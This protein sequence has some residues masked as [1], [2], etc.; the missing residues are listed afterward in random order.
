MRRFLKRLQARL[1]LALAGDRAFI[2]RAF[3]EILGRDPDLDGLNHYRRVL[4]DGVGRT[5]VLLDIL[6]S[7]ESVGR[8]VKPRDALVLPDLRAERPDR[9]RET[10]DRANGETITVFDIAS[11]ADVDWL[12]RAI[13][14]HRYYEKPGVWNLGVD[15]DKR[16]V[17]EIIAAF[18]P[19]QALELGCAAG[20]VL[21]CL[22]DVGIAAEGVEI[23]TMAIAKASPR[24]RP[25]IHQG[26][27]LLLDLPHAYDMVFGLDV[28]E[29]LNPNRIDD[30]V[31]RLAR[32]TAADAMLF[33]NIPAFGDDPVFGTVFP[34][35]V[36]GWASD[37]AAGRTFSSIHVDTL[38]YPIHGHLTWAD[39]RW[40]VERFAA[41]GFARAPEIERTL[42]R[43]Y[44]DFM[45][46]H[47]PARRSFFVFAKGAMA[48]RER[49]IISAI[50]GRPS[51][52]VT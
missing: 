2:E 42:H 29:H 4:G 8:L 51:S 32:I 46:K 27:L 25:R 49:A 21:D 14:D 41:H 7:E 17:A 15:S 44:D 9:F 24:V 12:E 23:S 28:F 50:R 39:W 20:A 5:A 35:Y 30:Y 11:P 22:D 33:C 45:T 43:K 16:V 52:V 34:F 6:R 47:A 38:G 1:E 18:A 26:D 36:D 37:A 10:V 3:R 19:S 31:E 48:E 40:W 13:L